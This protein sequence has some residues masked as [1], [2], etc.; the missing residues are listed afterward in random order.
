MSRALRLSCT[1]ILLALALSAKAQLPAAPQA[2]LETPQTAEPQTTEPQQDNSFL[3]ARPLPEGVPSNP[4]Q[5]LYLKDKNLTWKGEYE[6]DKSGRPLLDTD[7]HVIPV[8][9]TRKGKRTR[10]V[11]VQ[12]LKMHPA[13]V[14]DGTLQIDG[15]NGEARLNYDIQD[16]HFLYVSVPR[17]GTVIISSGAFP[18]GEQQTSGFTDKVLD[19][20]INDHDI[21]LI[22]A[23]P[24]LGKDGTAPAWVKLDPNYIV[25]RRYPVFG[26]GRTLNEPFDWPGAQIANRRDE[27]KIAPPLSS[28]M[29]PRLAT[30]VC[31]PQSQKSCPAT[32]SIKNTI[33]GTR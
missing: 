17:L 21:Q 31:I 8:L 27:S 23:K 15:W 14:K 33:E 5:P 25:D 2:S 30:P 13:F 32:A 18:G 12:L 28:T 9:Y 20:R 1:A 11:G 4:P 7:T 29:L 16:F 22:T 10:P 24:I 6:F 19:V 26:Y 3:L